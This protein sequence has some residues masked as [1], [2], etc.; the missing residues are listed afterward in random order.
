[1]KRKVLV[2][3]DCEY[4]LKCLK[5][6][7]ERSDYEAVVL[8]DKVEALEKLKQIKPDVVITD[9]RSPGMGGLEFIR[10]VKEFDPSIP[11][12]IL[13]GSV[14]LKD[15]REAVRLGV[16]E[17]LNKPFDVASLRQAIERALETRSAWLRGLA[18]R[19]D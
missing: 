7:I 3:D 10:L 19:R 9:L 11:V 6:A 1:M 12:I 17:C 13:S 16:F 4:T 18:T 2:T 5:T 8:V 15:A 14:T